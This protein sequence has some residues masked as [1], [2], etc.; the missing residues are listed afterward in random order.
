MRTLAEW[1]I[2]DHFFQM[3]NDCVKLIT[4]QQVLEKETGGRFTFVG[5]SVNETIRL[6]L[7]NGM[8]KKAEKVWSDWKVPDKRFVYLLITRHIRILTPTTARYWYIK[9]YALTEIRD[10]ESLETFAASK[11]SP[12]GYEPFVT[13]LAKNGHKAQAARYV[14]KCD[15]KRRVD[16]YVVCGEWKKAALECKERGDR[17][18]LE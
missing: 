5:T 7:V 1:Q 16:M 2:P 14:P 15:A 3:M 13:H 11:K 12:I 10:F 4:L 8:T 6:C 18:K 17:A 9:L